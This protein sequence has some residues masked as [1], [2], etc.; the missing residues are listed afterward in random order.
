MG[1]PQRVVACAVRVRR[2]WRWGP[3]AGQ[4]IGGLPCGNEWA[5]S[6]T[7]P[8][9]P[10]AHLAGADVVAS[11]DSCSTAMGMPSAAMRSRLRARSA[12]RACS[13][14]VSI[15]AAPACG[16]VC[17]WGC[18]GWAAC[19]VVCVGVCAGVHGVYG[20]IEHG[21]LLLVTDPIIGDARQAAA[22]RGRAGERRACTFS[23]LPACPWAPPGLAAA[24]QCCSSCSREHSQL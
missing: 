22:G 12:L 23:H 20:V 15:L 8:A 13:Y 18:M 21:T 10:R 5:R 2:R 17:T 16:V 11:T 1:G 7:K 14:S 24:P 6:A 4:Q 3:K 19:G 9:A